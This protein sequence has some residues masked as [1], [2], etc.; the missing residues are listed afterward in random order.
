MN[1]HDFYAVIN[2]FIC[3]I[4]NSQGEDEVKPLQECDNFFDLGVLNSLSMVRLLVRVEEFLGL[5][6]D[7]TQYE[8]ES[9]FT[10]R[11]M[12]EALVAAEPAP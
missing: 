1:R 8:P 7:V 2:D 5:E 9:L 10:L 12:Y 4:N 11:G 3:D 6:I